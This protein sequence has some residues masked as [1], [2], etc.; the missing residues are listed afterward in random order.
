MASRKTVTPKNLEALGTTRLAELLIEISA[1]DANAR[2]QLRMELAAAQSPADVAREVRKRLA[3]IARSR[4]FVDWQKRRVLVDNLETQRRAIVET[5]AVADPEEAL[6][7]MWRFLDLAD[8]VFGRCDDSSGTV[9][10]VFHTASHDLGDIARAAGADPEALADRA[11]TA[12]NDNGYGQHDS[13]IGNLASA[14]GNR[15][16]DR[17]KARFVALSQTPGTTPP[18]SEREVLGWGSGGPI[19]ADDHAARHRDITI[20]MALREIADA[21]GD[22]DT[23]I[24]QHG[25]KARS[26][27]RVAAEIAQRLLA[28]GRAEEA[29]TAINAID[30]DRPGWIPL[31][32][33]QT[34]IDVLEA[35]GRSEDAQAFRWTCFERS[36]NASHLREFLKRI[37]DFDD[38]GAEERALAHALGYR[39]SH[40][41]L[42]FLVSWPALDK[43]A[44]LVM[45]RS[46]ELDGNRYEVLTPAAD[47]LHAQHPLAATVLRRAMID[48]ALDNARAKRYRHAARHLLEC[49]GLATAIGDFAEFDTHEEY[50]A[51]LRERHGRKTAFWAMMS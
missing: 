13:L 9:I 8:P 41:A 42:A 24:A 4:S 14:L 33:E 29:W 21:Q 30:E 50:L 49:E 28:A 12:L 20:R 7:L 34:R 23:F 46:H 3:T 17:L 1:G 22:V 38:I 26:V 18:A 43:A 31:E 32:W 27:P 51:R 25:E 19:Y 2:R 5:I 44:Q 47:A 40:R 11:F 37:P 10:G 48:F 35:L 16:L 39:D 15:G 36:L 45:T 6:D